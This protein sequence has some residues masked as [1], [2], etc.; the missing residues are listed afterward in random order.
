MR[1]VLGIICILFGGL[2]WGGQVLSSINYPLA[3]KL[4]LQEKS[5]GTDPLFRRAEINAAKWD[6]LILWTLWLSGV[7]MLTNNP[8]WQYLSLIAGGIYLDTAG[9]E[10]AKLL[11]LSK[12]GVGIGSPKD[13]KIVVIFFSA[14]CIIAIWAIAYSLVTAF[15]MIA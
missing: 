8:W 12:A 14:M 7:L 5:E 10:A 15:F 13:L 3:Q 4:G 6:S 2:C 1:I 9:R 11:S